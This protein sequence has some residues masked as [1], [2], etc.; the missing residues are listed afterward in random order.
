MNSRANQHSFQSFNLPFMRSTSHLSMP[1]ANAG[2]F[3]VN[4]N[5]TMSEYEACMGSVER[6][7]GFN[8]FYVGKGGVGAY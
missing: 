4:I 3:H 8:K 5:Y 7:R 2:I 6:K 1:P